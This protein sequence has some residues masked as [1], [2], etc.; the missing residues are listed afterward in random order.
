M[1]KLAIAPLPVDVPDLE[2]S[3]TKTAGSGDPVLV[4]LARF[5][6]AAINADC[7]DAFERISGPLPGLPDV[8]TGD[9]TVLQGAVRNVLLLNPQLGR[10]FVEADAPIL[11]LHR[12]R[13]NK[14]WAQVAEAL[15]Q[16]TT[17]VVVQWYPGGIANDDRIN[18]DP[19]NTALS[20]A[21]GRAVRFGRHPAWIHPDDQP[22]PE[23]IM[24]PRQVPLVDTTFDGADLNGAWAGSVLRVAR[25]VLVSTAPAPPGTYDTTNPITV[26]GLDERGRA[27]S[28]T[29]TPTDADGGEVLSTVWPFTQVLAVDAPAQGAGNSLH[30]GY[31]AAPDVFKLGS[32]IGQH[33]R[34]MYLTVERDG[35]IKRLLI[36]P[37][38]SL[39]NPGTPPLSY[40]IEVFELALAVV[41]NI[42]PDSLVHADPMVTGGGTFVLPKADNE[43]FA[44]MAL[45][46]P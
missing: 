46:V 1:D 14:A 2:P 6:A 16:R 34:L 32:V 17:S 3:P 28:D 31:A 25:P 29:V 30:V 21:V 7:K 39:V 33:A 11:F 4:L 42:R 5:L 37:T 40:E 26:H 15:H 12:A 19:F 23:A 41:E 43:V 35:E 45:P 10:G 20:A 8:G 24:F 9:T 18:R 22:Q 38:M 13:N 44:T 27:W 36:K